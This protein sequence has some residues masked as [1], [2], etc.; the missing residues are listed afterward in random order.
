MIYTKFGTPVLLEDAQITPQGAEVVA[1]RQDGSL[2]S[3]GAWC[4]IENFRADGGAKEINTVVD[5]LLGGPPDP[6]EAPDDH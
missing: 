4:P 5:C 6:L 3:G 1:K 2:V